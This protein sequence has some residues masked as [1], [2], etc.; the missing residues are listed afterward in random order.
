MA[1]ALGVA[2]VGLA[3]CGEKPEQVET[4]PE[5][6]EGISITDA[7]LMLPAVKGNPGAAYFDV[8]NDSAKSVMIRA[9]SV[10]GAGCAMLHQMGTWNN[11]PSMDEILQIA[12]PANGDLKFEPGGLH[13]MANDLADTVTAGGTA[14][15]TLTFVGGD[16]ISF[17]A[18]VRAAGDE[19]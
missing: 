12:V 19:R 16:K 3:G 13:V 17:P 8:K 14:E 9:V 11:Q 4:G 5:A 1:A 15:V 18:E 10:A 6:P 7:R 2:C